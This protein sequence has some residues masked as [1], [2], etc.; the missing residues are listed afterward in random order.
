MYYRKLLCLTM[1]SGLLVGLFPWTVVGQSEDMRLENINIPISRKSQVVEA[2][3]PMAEAFT[4]TK[5]LWEVIQ[6]GGPMLVP[7]LA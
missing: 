6:A 5:S 4:S 7:L 2:A 1:T 3:S